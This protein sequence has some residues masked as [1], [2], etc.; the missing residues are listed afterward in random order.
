MSQIHNLSAEPK[1]RAGKGAARATRREGKVPAVIYGDKKAP[2]MVALESREVVRQIHKP[3]FFSHIMQIMVDGKKHQVLA[4]DL[5]LDPVK[6]TPIHIDFLRVSASSEITVNVPVHFTGEEESPGLA[7]GGVLNV[8]RHEVEVICKASLIPEELVGNLAGLDIGD[9][10]HIS[11]FELPE[12]VRPTIDDRDFTV[13]TIAAPS[14]VKA[15]AAEAQAEE[16]AE[17]EEEEIEGEETEAEGEESE[18]E[19]EESE[20]E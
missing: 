5:Q 19:E 3:G 10:L 16:E 8:V 12:G 4:R 18:G 20:K 7:R 15:E 11:N 13:A 14:A 2:L 6:D 1:E 9:S 17:G